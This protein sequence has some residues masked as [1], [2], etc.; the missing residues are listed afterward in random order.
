MIV[1]RGVLLVTFFAFLP[2]K[3]GDYMGSFRNLDIT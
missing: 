1:R 2:I 3:V